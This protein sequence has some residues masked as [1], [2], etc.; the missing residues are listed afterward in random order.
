[1]S[2]LSVRRSTRCLAN[3]VLPLWVVPVT[4]APVS[5]A[6]TKSKGY[7]AE[8]KCGLIHHIGISSFQCVCVSSVMNLFPSGLTD[9]VMIINILKKHFGRAA[10]W[11]PFVE[12]TV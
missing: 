12:I 4:I 3:V 1:M 10:K 7:V 2:P 6:S 9:G 5:R 11:V 8:V